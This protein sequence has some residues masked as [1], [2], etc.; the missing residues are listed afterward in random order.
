MIKFLIVTV[1]MGAL[2]ACMAG[3]SLWRDFKIQ[4]KRLTEAYQRLEQ[5]NEEILR[6][7]KYIG[8]L[9]S[10]IATLKGKGNKVPV[11]PEPN[12]SP[13]KPVDTPLPS[14]HPFPTYHTSTTTYKVN[15]KKVGSL[16]PEQQK[17]LDDLD[18]AMKALDDALK[19]LKEI[20]FNSRKT[21]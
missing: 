15:G 1:L 3:L 2:I 11:T 16:T 20:D 5:R 8:E 7:I 10:E 14:A 18:D 4:K 17:S 21:Q 13:P 19:S 9:Q 6:Y 12:Q